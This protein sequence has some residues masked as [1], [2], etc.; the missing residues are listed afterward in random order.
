M[1]DVLFI[2]TLKSG[3]ILEVAQYAIES[4]KYSTSVREVDHIT[5]ALHYRLHLAENEYREV[6]SP[7]M[8]ASHA[9]VV[10]S[11]GSNG[12]LPALPPGV[13]DSKLSTASSPRR[14]RNT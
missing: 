4:V 8:T 11:H 5:H 6:L 12:P 9:F 10:I 3:I 2:C 13:S 7:L 1:Y 14:G